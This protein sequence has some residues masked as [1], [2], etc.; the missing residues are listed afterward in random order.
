MLDAQKAWCVEQLLVSGN[1]EDVTLMDPVGS[2]VS[3]L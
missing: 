2:R 3:Y 1:F